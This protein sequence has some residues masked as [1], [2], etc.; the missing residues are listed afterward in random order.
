MPGSASS[1]SPANWHNL[2]WSSSSAGRRGARAP[3]AEQRPAR[4]NQPHLRTDKGRARPHLFLQRHMARPRRGLRGAR[5]RLPPHGRAHGQ[6]AA[7]LGQSQGCRVVAVQLAGTAAACQAAP[8]LLPHGRLRA[9]SGARSP[10]LAAGG[11]RL[12]SGARPLRLVAGGHRRAQLARGLLRCLSPTG[13]W[14]PHCAGCH[15]RAQ[16]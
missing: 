16:E 3:T 11:V 15:A 12:A 10:R 1:P 14:R 5:G 2:K 8:A 9:A 6:V 13:S 4:A 7:A